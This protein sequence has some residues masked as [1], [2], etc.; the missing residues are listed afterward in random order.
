MKDMM[1][2]HSNKA[3]GIRWFLG[4]VFLI[5]AAG[6]SCLLLMKEMGV[7]GVSLPGCG[8]QSA[9]GDL[10]RGFFGSVPGVGWPTSYVG[11][12]FFAAMMVAWTACWPKVPR[13]IVL[14]VRLGVLM[15]VVFMVVILVEW[16]LC[17]YCITAHLANIA[18]W[19]TVEYSKSADT[20]ETMEGSS[21]NSITTFICSFVLLTMGLYVGQTQVDEIDGIRRAASEQANIDEIVKA[22]LGGTVDPTAD[23]KKVDDGVFEA[24]KTAVKDPTEFGG[25]YL[26]GPENAPVQI[27]MVGDYQCP[28][29]NRYE[30]IVAKILESRDDVSLSVRHFPFNSDCNPYVSRTMHGNACWAAKFAETA[31]ILGGEEAFWNAH[32]LLFEVKGSFTRDEFPELVQQ[33]GFDRQ[34]FEQVMVGPVVDAVVQE[35]IEIGGQL[36]VYFTP[37]IFINGVQLKWWQNPVDLSSTVDQLA[38]AI[39]DGRNDG[40]LKAPPSTEQK[41]IDDWR[42]GPTRSTPDRPGL[43]MGMASAPHRIIVFSDYTDTQL[44]PVDER[45]RKLMKKYPG[46]IKYD[47]MASPKNPDCNSKVLDRFRDLFPSGC[48][49]AKA[50]KASAKLGDK[51]GYWG[52]IEYLMNA[53]QQVTQPEIVAAA[54]SLGMDRDQFIETMNSQEIDAQVQTDV[55]RSRGW[56]MRTFPAIVVDGKLIPRWKLEDKPIIEQVVEI[57]VNGESEE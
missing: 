17:P 1:Q 21:M 2:E 3:D 52:M 44:K 29:C 34:T 23:G 56:G 4:L 30:K 37:M 38:K 36:G 32:R 50:V 14:L 42:T 27:V 39:A 15:S 7:A 33:L 45:I 5:V 28:D 26:L 24:P 22:T 25:R 35:D 43:S 57:A 13:S 47:I 48:I 41:Y 20:N 16:K 19:I 53:G 18:F 31:G 55:L 6:A 10:S 8:E 46:Q 12:T 9:C 54:V 40:S 51:E 11:F 49:A